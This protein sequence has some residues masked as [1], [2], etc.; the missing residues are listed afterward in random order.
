MRYVRQ[1][2]L[3]GYSLYSLLTDDK[4][5]KLKEDNEFEEHFVFIIEDMVRFYNEI[6]MH[7]S[8]RHLRLIMA[9][10]DKVSVIFKKHICH[11]LPYTIYCWKTHD[12]IFLIML[13]TYI[14]ALP[15]VAWHPVVW[16]PNNIAT[17]YYLEQPS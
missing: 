11:G 6:N 9:M 5:H 2:T 10:I 8:W 15:K 14:C 1:H 4:A 12:L 3:S 16:H 17:S 13:S 7:L